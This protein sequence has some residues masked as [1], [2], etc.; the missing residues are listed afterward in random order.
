M[1]NRLYEKA[2]EAANACVQ[3]GYCLPAC[4]TYASMGKESASPRGRIHL[5]KMAA[6]GKIDVLRDLR[7]PIDLCLGCRACE[8]ACPSGVRYGRLL[9]EVR[10][11]T[12]PLKPPGRLIRVG[13]RHLIP[14]PGP[15]RA[16]GWLAAL[17]QR[18]GLLRLLPGAFGDLARALP[19][20]HPARP[21]RA[22]RAYR[23]ARVLSGGTGEEKAGQAPNGQTVLFFRGCIQDAFLFHQNEAAIRVVTAAGARCI[24]PAGQVCCGALHAH[25]GDLETARRLARKNIAAFERYPGPIV[26]HAGGCGAHLKECAHLLRDDPEWAERARAFSARV[27]DFSQWLAEVGLPADALSP[28][29]LTVT[30]QDSCHLVHGQKVRRQPRDLIRTIPGIR[31]REMNGADRCC[32]SAGIYNL[33]HPEMADRVLREKMARV[34]E[35]GAQVVV[36]ANPGCYLQLRLGVQQAGLEGQVEVLSLAELLDR[37]LR[38]PSPTA[39]AVSDRSPGTGACT[40][41]SGGSDT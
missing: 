41:G 6:E 29:P 25:S 36:T 10:V 19:R 35:T 28:L 2:Y 17:A 23:T 16:V 9:E 14:Y 12:A 7:P 1:T 39:P 21:Y 13:L 37:S 4:P 3:C 11:L 8:S 18:L 33:V 31:Y 15:L 5:V 38:G 20:I 40:G 22:A 27:M 32:G 34:A 24:V 26:T 30:Y